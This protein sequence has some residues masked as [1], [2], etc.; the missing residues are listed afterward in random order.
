[1]FFPESDEAQNLWSCAE[2]AAPLYV[3]DADDDGDLFD[4]TLVSDL[5]SHED[6][7]EVALEVDM[8][9]RRGS[10]EPWLRPLT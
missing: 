10:P 4:L 6:T 5:A 2:G 8:P 3:R 1:M 9:L 7:D